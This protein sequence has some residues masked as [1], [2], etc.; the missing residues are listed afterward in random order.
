VDVV[1]IRHI[2]LDSRSRSASASRSDKNGEGIPDHAQNLL[3]YKIRQTSCLS[4][5]PD[6]SS[7]TTSSIRDRRPL[8]I[9]R[10]GGALDRDFPY[11][12]LPRSGPARQGFARAQR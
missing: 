8:I 7:S 1:D 5:V 4:S 3:C 2:V 12:R 6:P 11:R 10:A 9:A